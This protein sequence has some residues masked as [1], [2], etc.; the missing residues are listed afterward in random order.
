MTIHEAIEQFEQAREKVTKGEWTLQNY[1]AFIA[2]AHESPLPQLARDL[3]AE[4]ARLRELVRELR[5][6]AA[7]IEN[8]GT[9]CWYV[10]VIVDGHGQYLWHDGTLHNET[11][12]PRKDAGYFADESVA[13]KTLANYTADYNAATEAMLVPI[14]QPTPTRGAER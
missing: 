11:G 10:V 13:K 7:R 14:P 12:Y 3:L 5:V 9:G 1:A 4:N 8:A 2:L 6:P